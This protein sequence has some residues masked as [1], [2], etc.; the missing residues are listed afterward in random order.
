MQ[1][2]RIAVGDGER[3]E[4]DGKGIADQSGVEMLQVSRADNDQDGQH[5]GEKNAPGDG[6]DSL[7]AHSAESHDSQSIGRVESAP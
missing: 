1:P 5:G 7:A 3:G 6:H 4:E 2:H